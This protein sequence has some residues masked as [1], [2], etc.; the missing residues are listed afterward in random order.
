MTF[1]A[2]AAVLFMLGNWM[3]RSIGLNEQQVIRGIR[4]AYCY[5]TDAYE[6]DTTKDLPLLFRKELGGAKLNRINFRMDTVSLQGDSVVLKQD[7]HYFAD[8]QKLIKQNYTFVCPINATQGVRAHILNFRAE[9]IGK[10][11]YYFFA[12][13]VALC[14]LL[15]AIRKQINII[16]RQDELARVREDFSY[17]MIHDMKNPISSILM[18]LK[19]LRSGKVDDK[20]EKHEKYFDILETESQHLLALTNKVLTISKLEH[21]QLLLDKNWI[22]LR[23]MLE[24]SVDTFTAKADKPISFRLELEETGVYADEEYLKEVL[25]NLIDN[26][27]KYSKDTV[28]IQ[29]SS[30]LYNGYTQIRVRT[31]VSAS[32]LLPSALF[33]IS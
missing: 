12:T 16:H 27:I 26:A 33:S 30:C 9:F 6:A 29:I 23:P 3:G 32:P 17:A 22:E 11:L 5:T 4:E 18:G 8:Y 15:Y 24:A 20:P 21:G 2:T 13:I 31:T 28:E 14:I 10:L 25:S 19:V 1:A 7:L